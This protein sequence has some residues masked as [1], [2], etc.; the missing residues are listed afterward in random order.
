MDVVHRRLRRC[1][2][3]LGLVLAGLCGCQTWV[4]GMTM[5]T[6]WYLQHPP[7]YIPPSPAFPLTRELAS[8]EA[9]VAAPA[10][11]APAAPLP[12]PLPAPVPPPLPAPAPVPGGGGAPLPPPVPMPG[13]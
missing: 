1:R 8:Q 4:A 2:A 9:V 6:G 3:G 11:G 5:P 13:Q 12:A 7:Q 10:P